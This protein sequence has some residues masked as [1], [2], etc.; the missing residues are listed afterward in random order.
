MLN[1]Y[2]QPRIQILDSTGAVVET[3]NLDLCG[4]D[5]LIRTFDSF[6]IVHN[7]VG[8]EMKVKHRKIRNKYVLHY[9]KY[10]SNENTEKILSIINR[11]LNNKKII[12]TP[13]VDV[14]ELKEEV[15]CVN[16]DLQDI[17]LKL[18]VNRG[19]NTKGFEGIIL[20]FTGKYKQ[21]QIDYYKTE[22]VRYWGYGST[23]RSGVLV[24]GD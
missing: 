14:V 21:T 5:G 10:S 7:V 6:P 3:Y 20:R 17:K 22:W 12:L 1:G 13:R 8:G 18:M 4:E 23:Q 11:V 24:T 19:E 2:Q 15:V 16:S 9:S